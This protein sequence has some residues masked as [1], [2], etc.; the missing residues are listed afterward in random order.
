[1][2]FGDRKVEVTKISVPGALATTQ[3]QDQ[4]RLLDA[5]TT[6]TVYKWRVLF[7]ANTAHKALS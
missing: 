6:F 1:M 5:L 2:L 7:S 3:P 4:G